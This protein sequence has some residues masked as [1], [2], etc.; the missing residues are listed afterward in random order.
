M[1]NRDIWFGV[2]LHLLVLLGLALA[3]ERLKAQ[4]GVLLVVAA[5]ALAPKHAFVRG[6]Q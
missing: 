6:A 1:C 5:E 3:Y 4:L 2:Q